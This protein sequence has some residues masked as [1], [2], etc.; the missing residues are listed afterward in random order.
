M[1]LYLISYMLPL[2]SYQISP[3]DDGM[4][5]DNLLSKLFKGIPKSHLYRLLRTGKIKLNNQKAEFTTKV[6][7]TDQLTFPNKLNCQKSSNKPLSSPAQLIHS[8]GLVSKL[9]P[10]F[11][12]KFYLIVNK[13][14]GFACHGGSGLSFGV[15]EAIREHYHYP[16]IELV[17]RLDKATSGLL[18]LAKTRQALVKL[19]ELLR[20]GKVKKHYFALVKGAFAPETQIIDSPLFKFV[21]K[22]GK[23]V[24]R[25]QENGQKAITHVK[26]QKVYQKKDLLISAVDVWLETGRTHQIRVHL[27]SCGY[28]I[29]GDEQYGDFELNKFLGL[30]LMFLQAKSLEFIHPITGQKTSLTIPYSKGIDSFLKT[31]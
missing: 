4:R 21:T 27:A 28:P 8:S 30:K 7:L 10:V 18:I 11:E 17:H 6:K 24:V 23:R 16:F 22:E 31:L 19:Q 12:D 20:E 26:L 29:L 2:S 14:H 1:Q 25:V 5:L 13:P 9:Q 3:S 15:I